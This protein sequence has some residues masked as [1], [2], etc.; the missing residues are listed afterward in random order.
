MPV[1]ATG[2]LHTTLPQPAAQWAELLFRQS[3]KAKPSKAAGPSGV[4]MEAYQA[5]DSVGVSFLGEFA[6]QAARKGPP[7]VQ[8]LSGRM[9]PVPRAWGAVFTQDSVRGVLCDDVAGKLF[10]AAVGAQ[11]APHLKHHAATHLHGRNA[12]TALE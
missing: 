4:P 11:A 3:A 12:A 10:S 7:P 9:V 8:W 2:A 1:A 5:L 6:A